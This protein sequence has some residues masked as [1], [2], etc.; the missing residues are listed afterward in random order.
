MDEA[1]LRKMRF[2]R[3]LQLVAAV[4]FLIAAISRFATGEAGVFAWVFVALAL[5]SAGTWF[6]TNR[7]IQRFTQE[8]HGS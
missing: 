2:S 4:G 5:V 6:V 3:T 1:T 7:T 8:T